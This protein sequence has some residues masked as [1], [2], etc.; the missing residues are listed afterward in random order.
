MVLLERN[1][2]L[3]HFSVKDLSSQI[4]GHTRELRV[5]IVQAAL[6]ACN[7]CRDLVTDEVF[8][9]IS[10]DAEKLRSIAAAKC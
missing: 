1:P 2:T 3:L 5:T 10:A 6:V 8:T 9:E 4:T 7:F